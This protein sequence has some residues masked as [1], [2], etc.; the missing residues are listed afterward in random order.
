MQSMQEL[1]TPNP[2]APWQPPWGENEEWFE[3]GNSIKGPEAAQSETL[4]HLGLPECCCPT[5][6]QGSCDPDRSLAWPNSWGL[7]CHVRMLG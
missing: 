5:M 6:S 7:C 4:L 3:A 2:T 1:V